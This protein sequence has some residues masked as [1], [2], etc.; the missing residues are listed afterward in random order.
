MY[1][2][3]TAVNSG[4]W[5]G[6]CRVRIQLKKGAEAVESCR[7]NK[8]NSP[9]DASAAIYLVRALLV[10]ESFEEAAREADAAR[11]AHQHHREVHEVFME[12]E[13]AKKM[14]LRIDYYKV[15]SVD[16]SAGERDVKKAY[17]DLA[18]MYHPDKAERMGI[19]KEEAEKKF[20]EIAEAYEVLSSEEKR[21]AYDRGEDLDQLFGPGAQQGHGFPGGF[22]GGFQGGFQG[23]FHGG[24]P[25]GFQSGGFGHQTFHFEF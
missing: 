16:K 11:R 2:S 13:K 21:A 7:K 19:D 23:G 3:A 14:A 18:R 5:L 22:P 9:D 17:R 8:D 20:R 1:P 4:M 24:F 6:L 25:G 12:A 15:L 10:A